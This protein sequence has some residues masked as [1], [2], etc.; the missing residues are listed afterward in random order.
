MVIINQM[1]LAK[2]IIA[3]LD[4]K[5]KKLIK[6]IRFEGLRVIG[7]AIDFAEKYYLNGVDE[8]L[9]IDAV[10]SLYGRN[11]LYEILSE[12]SKRIFV[13]ITAGGGIRSI[14]DAKALISNGAD[15][16]AINTG[17]VEDI[18]LANRLV[19]VFGSQ[20][21]VASIQA[22]KNPN[23]GWEVMK[24]SGRERTGIAV[25]DWINV[26]QQE[27][28]GEILI[29]SVDNDGLSKGIDKNL[30]EMS[31]KI[32]KIPLIVGGGFGDEN[33]IYSSI[34][35]PKI[36]GVSIGASFHKNKLLIK[37]LKDK[38]NLND[39]NLIRVINSE[40]D[41][42][43]KNINKNIYDLFRK[44]NLL[45]VDYGLGNH[46]SLFNSLEK[47][48]YKVE[49]SSSI[50]KIKEADLIFLPGVGSFSEGIKNLKN[51]GIYN[52][53]IESVNLGKPIIGICLGMQM[54][55]DKGYEDGIN[56][57]LGLIKGEV[58][59]MGKI[60]SEKKMLIPH[61]GWN[62]IKSNQEDLNF[63]EL[64]S[65]QYFVHSFNAISVPAENKL[66]SFNY[67][68]RDWIASIIHE[69]I[70]GFQFHPERSG[71]HGLRLLDYF[72][73]FLLKQK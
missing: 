47:L 51:K 73:E 32:C 53:L 10:A 44:K 5:G 27:G 38:I 25:N 54:M 18:G 12:T 66:F 50:K 16:V 39:S 7:D 3:R 69:N 48:D 46:Q 41:F 19:K 20:C 49:I 30:I 65:M 40:I 55:L 17:L 37:T 35:N 72:V 57:G 63:K 36:S 23:L 71:I 62:Y 58:Q 68:Q 60:H 43:T 14:E 70:I 64:N 52:L 13:P 22:K 24:A 59:Y 56:K 26:L 2:R 21:I 29:T 34:K 1:G 61:I 6:G 28:V 45:I 33:E 9:Y 11:S 15:K 4:I 31:S 8:I 67:Y 42:G